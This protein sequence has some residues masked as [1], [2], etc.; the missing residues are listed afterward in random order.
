MLQS[1]REDEFNLIK[2]FKF[3][4]SIN[5]LNLSFVSHLRTLQF[6]N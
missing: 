5:G 2:N 3:D 6:L 4:L 1:C